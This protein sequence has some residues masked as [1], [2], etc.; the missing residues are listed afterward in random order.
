MLGAPFAIG[1]GL[2]MGSF[3]S[4]VKKKSTSGHYY[5]WIFYFGMA[6]PTL[7]YLLRFICTI[8]ANKLGINLPD[9]L[10]NLHYPSSWYIPK[11]GH[12]FFCLPILAISCSQL[13]Y[14]IRNRGGGL[15]PY[16]AIYVAMIALTLAIF[17]IENIKN[18]TLYSAILIALMFLQIFITKRFDWSKKRIFVAALFFVL[19]TSFLAHDF[20]KNESWKTIFPDIFVAMQTDKFD[21]WKYYGGK[22]YPLNGIGVPASA[23]NYDRVAWAQVATKLILEEPLGYGLVLGSFGHMAKDKWP[24]SSLLQS[25]SGWLDLTLGIGIPG[26]LLIVLAG[27]LVLINILDKKNSRWK[28]AIIWVLGCVALLMLTTEVSQKVFV[29]ALIFLVL[30]ASGMGLYPSD[31]SV[32]KN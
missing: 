21:S 23:S 1:V 16:C 30:M 12:V 9:V 20:R 17:N 22:G 32:D 18:G 4:N 25:H 14:E 28:S 19:T 24:D 10:M 3:A 11:P 13:V 6:L 31:K 27:Y 26:V 7:I 15:K 2:A 8:V 5:W 29:D